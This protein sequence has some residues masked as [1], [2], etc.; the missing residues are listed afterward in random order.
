MTKKILS[1]VISLLILFFVFPMSAVAES[2]NETTAKSINNKIYFDCGSEWENVTQ[3]YCHIQAI[4]GRPFFYWQSGGEKCNKIGATKWEYDLSELLNSTNNPNGLQPDVDY[5]LLFSDAKGRTTYEVT[6]GVECIGD[7]L[8]LTGNTLENPIDFEQI[9]YEACW[10]NNSSEFGPHL[11]I[12]SSGKVIGSKLAPNETVTHIVGDWLYYFYDIKS[13]DVVKSLRI[14]LNKFKI[15]DPLPICEYIDLTYGISDDRVINMKEILHQAIKENRY[16]F[17]SIYGTIIYRKTYTHIEVYNSIE[18]PKYKSSDTK[19]VKVNSSGL[20]KGLKKGKATVTVSYDGIEKKIK[21]KVINPR[22]NYKK[23][24][25]SS[26]LPRVK[27][28][29]IGGTGKISWK[30]SKPKVATVN[31]KGLVKMKKAG[32][33]IITAK[34]NGIALK[35]KVKCSDTLVKKSVKTKKNRK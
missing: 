17:V 9:R 14:A 10:N 13:F 22:L 7:T 4:G 25:I 12:S 26:C 18:K 8:T 35:C 3:V 31:K 28:R 16:V 20:V 24:S 6:F 1:L 27:L 19:I 23:V 21:I 11:A 33:A 5:I 15:D 29:Y 34:R 32:T 30:S 2:N